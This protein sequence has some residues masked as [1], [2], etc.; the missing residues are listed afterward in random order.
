[1]RAHAV[2][3][4]PIGPLT[5]VADDGVLVRLHL[6]PPGPHEDLGPRDDAALAA[7]IARS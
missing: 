6:S 7:T 2:V 3:D 5:V 4:S 1:M